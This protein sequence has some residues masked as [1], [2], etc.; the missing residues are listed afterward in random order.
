L[1][2]LYPIPGVAGTAARKAEKV[3]WQTSPKTFRWKTNPQYRVL[4]NVVLDVVKPGNGKYLGFGEQGGMSFVKQPT[5]M[6]FF[7]KLLRY[8][9]L[10]THRSCI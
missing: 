10:I 4:K 1:P 5:F 6:N 3:I 2:D 9:L 8:I 7:S